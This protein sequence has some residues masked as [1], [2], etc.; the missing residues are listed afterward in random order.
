[1]DRRSFI[2]G[3]V[4]ATTGIIPD[5]LSANTLIGREVKK[6]TSGTH[7]GPTMIT[8]EDGVIVDVAP[9]SFDSNPSLL[10]KGI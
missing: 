9:L 10:N 5:V 2:K 8:V 6:V 7:W 1:M 4:I 3:S